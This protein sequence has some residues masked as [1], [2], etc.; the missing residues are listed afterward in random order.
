MK[1]FE[2]LL[3]GLANYKVPKKPLKALRSM[4]DH[5]SRLDKH[6]AAIG[7]PD[8][9]ALKLQKILQQF[10]ISSTAIFLLKKYT[11]KRVLVVQGTARAPIGTPAYD[12]IVRIVSL[13]GPDWIIVH[14]GGGGIM[15]AA[16]VGGQLGGSITVGLHFDSEFVINGA[17][18]TIDPINLYHTEFYSR[19]FAF[20]EYADAILI[21]EGGLGTLQEKSWAEGCI[22]CGIHR[23]IPLF[24]LSKK[25]WKHLVEHTDLLIE[26]KLVSPSDKDLIRVV[27]EGKEEEVFSRIEAYYAARPEL[28]AAQ[29]AALGV[30]GT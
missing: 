26:Q 3:E 20:L 7:L 21:D 9:Q 16:R 22:Q 8:S 23:T 13:A 30:V 1:D 19:M 18:G 12:R 28:V 6:Y 11:G 4:I 15:D 24:I 2:Q 27:D 14:G 5:L 10:V 29:A 17:S 25:F